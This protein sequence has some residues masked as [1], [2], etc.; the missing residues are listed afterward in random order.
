[1]R[2]AGHAGRVR[3][4]REGEAG[5]AGL[6]RGAGR[7]RR[8]GQASGAGPRPK[9]TV[10][11]SHSASCTHISCTDMQG[12]SCTVRRTAAVCGALHVR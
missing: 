3:L 7:D 1:M 5:E 10:N 8:Q 11:D 2:C 4:D 6:P 9:C 12:L